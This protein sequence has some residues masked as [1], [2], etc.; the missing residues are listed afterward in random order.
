MD[1]RERFVAHDADFAR[2]TGPTPRLV[3]VVE[4]DAH[5]GPVYV[6]GE[7]ALY[8]TSVPTAAMPGGAPSAVI[9][10]LALDGERFPIEAE[11]VAGLAA[12]VTMPNG[13]ALGTDGRLV[14]CEQGG[15]TTDAVI[16]RIDPATGQRSLV[17]GAWRG[18][19]LNSP[20]DVVVAGDGGV[21]FSD[22]S[23]GHLQGFRPRPEVGDLVYRWDPVRGTADVV[24]D[25]FD[26]PNG[27]AFSPDG[28]TLYVTDSGANQE[29]GSFHPDRPHHVVAFDVVAGRR[30]ANRRLLAV[31]GPGIPDGLETDADGRVYVSADRGVLVLSPDGDLLGEIRL[32]GAVN[33]TFGGPAG[34][35]LFVTADTAVWAAVLA[36]TGP[37]RPTS[38]PVPPTT[39][40]TVPPV[41]GRRPPTIRPAL[42]GAPA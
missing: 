11:R 12:D 16:S 8:V 32:P 15:P 14:V 21:W 4:V 18:R 6:A 35:V 25:G 22:P 28:S 17:V 13:M 40:G 20:N 31:T 9:R 2:V 36:V 29:P 27:L 38:R 33:F 10:R 41:A 37:R 3:R 24:A 5:E 23:Y 30:L 42:R 26:K 39:D 34:N 19:T 7:D 1:G